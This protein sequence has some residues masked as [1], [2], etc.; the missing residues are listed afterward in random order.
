MVSSFLLSL[1]CVGIIELR[2]VYVCVCLSVFGN[3]E[4]NDFDQNSEKKYH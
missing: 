2:R 1:D 4:F 3:F